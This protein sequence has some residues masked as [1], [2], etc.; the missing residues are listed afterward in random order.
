[1]LASILPSSLQQGIHEFGIMGNRAK[2]SHRFLTA[3]WLLF[4]GGVAAFLA[5]YSFG[6]HNV[7]MSRS[8]FLEKEIRNLHF[9]ETHEPV[10]YARAAEHYEW[11]LSRIRFDGRVHDYTD[12]YE[13]ALA[14]SLKKAQIIELVRAYKFT[15][16]EQ[17]LIEAHEIFGSSSY[18]QL[19]VHNFTSIFHKGE[20]LSEAW[21][22]EYIGEAGAESGRD[23]GTMRS[24]C[25]PTVQSSAEQFYETRRFL[26][27]AWN[28]LGIVVVWLLISLAGVVSLFGTRKLLGG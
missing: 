22:L 16:D 27:G 11:L 4:I 3:W 1:M 13:Q 28:F 21:F 8:F 2:T 5:A 7:P 18:R 15:G 24:G 20:R 14:R 23:P 10:D 6:H 25:N 19:E 12:Q 17:S 9:L 26:P